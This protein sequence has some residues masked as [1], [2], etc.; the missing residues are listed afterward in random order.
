MSETLCFAYN[1]LST[2]QMEQFL[3][4]DEYY[5]YNEDHAVDNMLY[6]QL[7]ECGGMP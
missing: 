7:F 1:N 3:Y 4:H 6:Y 2:I 5:M